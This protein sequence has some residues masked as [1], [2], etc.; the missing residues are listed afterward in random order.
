MIAA[1]RYQA[2]NSAQLF[3]HVVVLSV[4]C[5]NIPGHF[6]RNCTPAFSAAL[7]ILPIW[8]LQDLHLPTV[9]YHSNQITLNTLEKNTN[10]L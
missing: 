1:I 9:S 4:Q 7:L 6:C 8:S 10:I 2:H 3:S 5:T